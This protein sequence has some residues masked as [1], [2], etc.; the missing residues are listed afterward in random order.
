MS[1]MMLLMAIDTATRACGVSEVGS[2]EISVVDYTVLNDVL[3]AAISTMISAIRYNTVSD[4]DMV[5]RLN[6][7][8]HRRMMNV[9]RVGMVGAAGLMVRM[10]SKRRHERNNN[11]V[12]S[13]IN[14]VCTNNKPDCNVVDSGR[15]NCSP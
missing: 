13:N 8:V 14:V 6:N 4:T 15:R 7:E 2:G 11:S 5:A 1:L 3:N 10:R 12:A 9:D